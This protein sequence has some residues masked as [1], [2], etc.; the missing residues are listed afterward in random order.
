MKPTAENASCVVIEKGEG[1]ESVNVGP[2]SEY[3]EEI[4]KNDRMKPTSE[5]ESCVAM[6][7]GE[8]IEE[9]RSE[10]GGEKSNSE[11][12][13]NED[14]FLSKGSLTKKVNS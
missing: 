8:S 12:N 6:E 7:V 14:Y 3:V 5:N 9:K 1:K 13:D 4:E 2:L 11:T 10:C